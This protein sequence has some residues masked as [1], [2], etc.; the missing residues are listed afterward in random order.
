MNIVSIIVTYNRKALLKESIEAVLNQDCA[1]KK[2]L[3]ID[4]N[5]DD[6]TM[7]LVQQYSDDERV[8]Y[9]KLK[10]NIGGS[11]GFYEGLKAAQKYNP[12]WLWIMDDDC[13]P[14]P[15]CLQ[16]LG[17]AILTL[18]GEKISF[19]ASAVFGENGEV[20]NVPRISKILD[21]NG[22]P[23]WCKYL[24][25][26]IVKIDD[27]TFVSLLINNKA[28]I[29]CGLPVRDYFIWGDDTEYTKRI[30]KYYG[31]AFMVGK[32]KVIHKRKVAKALKLREENEPNRIRL[33]YYYVR[34]NLIN[35]R[36]Y[37]GIRK[38]I[39]RI[40][41]NYLLALKILLIPNCK[42]RLKKISVL[43]KGT[44]AFIFKQYD[45]KAFKKRLDI[46]VKYKDR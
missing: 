6:G 32:S 12:D 45:Y 22:Y 42:H 46:N 24:E 16:A 40:I 4:N 23:I 38:A 39:V 17:N 25:N 28:I 34:N 43:L 21:K 5:S 30:I 11:G 7:E 1:I 18:K 37:T 36:Y 27:A 13:I 44:N 33:Y 10:N 29:N 41:K 19:L 31:P 14:E 8:V 3:I 2:L 26:S 20:M 9:I 15:N 35:I